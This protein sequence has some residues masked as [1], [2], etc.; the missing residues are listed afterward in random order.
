MLRRRLLVNASG[1]V[2]GCAVECLQGLKQRAGAARCR[3]LIVRLAR[4]AHQLAQRRAIGAGILPHQRLQCHVTLRE[5][6]VPPLL[7]AMEAT[8]LGR[9]GNLRGGERRANGGVV[10]GFEDTGQMPQLA[11]QGAPAQTSSQISALPYPIGQ[12]QS[13]VNAIGTFNEFATQRL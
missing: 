6:T 3:G 7:E 13:F 4:T 10:L 1:G 2:A 8:H 12:R 11:L 5:Q 9:I